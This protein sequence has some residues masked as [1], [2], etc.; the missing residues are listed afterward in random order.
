MSAGL[1][2]ICLLL[3]AL[4]LA[5]CDLLQV[6]LTN[7]LLLIVTSQ[8]VYVSS[9]MRDSSRVK[10]VRMSLLAYSRRFDP[11]ELG[12]SSLQVQNHL[13]LSFLHNLIDCV[14]SH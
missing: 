4:C 8:G 11:T 14:F 13:S 9:D 7:N 10:G 5:G 6:I 1:S 2:D 12:C 3:L